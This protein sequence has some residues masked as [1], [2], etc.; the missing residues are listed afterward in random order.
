MIPIGRP[1]HI[2]YTSKKMPPSTKHIQSTSPVQTDCLTHDQCTHD[3]ALDVRLVPQQQSQLLVE[4]QLHVIEPRASVFL[5][6]HR[7]PSRA[8]TRP[9]RSQLLLSVDLTTRK[10]FHFGGGGKLDTNTVNELR[11]FLSSLIR[12]VRKWIHNIGETL[13]GQTWRPQQA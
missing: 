4:A 9:R 8:V 3:L 10:P 13:T 6:V 1:Q 5:R 12:G 7:R 2:M 11:F